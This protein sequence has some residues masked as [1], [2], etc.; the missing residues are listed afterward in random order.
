[1]ARTVVITE[2]FVGKDEPRGAEENSRAKQSHRDGHLHTP[3]L[4]SAT[5]QLSLTG[6]Q[7]FGGCA[8]LNLLVDLE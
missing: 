4:L 3:A 1:M 8:Q 2:K 5:S 6:K 7:L